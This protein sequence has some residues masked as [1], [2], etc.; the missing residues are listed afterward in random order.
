MLSRREAKIRFVRIVDEKCAKYI[1]QHE[2][3]KK[4]ILDAMQLLDF[5]DSSEE[6][7]D[8]YDWSFILLPLGKTIEGLYWAIG[9]EMGVVNGDSRDI[10]YFYTP[11][12]L[13]KYKNNIKKVLAKSG[14]NHPDNILESLY[15]LNSFLVR[16]RHT[17]AHFGGRFNSYEQAE[18][19]AKTIIYKIRNIIDELLDAGLIK[20]NKNV[21]A[22]IDLSEIP[23]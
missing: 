19:A 12:N 8:L 7:P 5:T 15:Q 9:N 21:H 23:F 4:N 17:P 1:D 20:I 2:E 16:F 14:V 22:E 18:A 6:L 3:V 10:G 11:Q 13:D